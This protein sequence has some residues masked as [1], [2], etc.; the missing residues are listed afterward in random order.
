MLISP[1]LCNRGGD[2]EAR[3]VF[4]L[5]EIRGC[6]LLLSDKIAE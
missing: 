1:A 4:S 6:C 2:N 3:S 5:K